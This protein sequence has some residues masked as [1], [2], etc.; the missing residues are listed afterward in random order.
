MKKTIGCLL[1]VFC[2]FYASGQTNITGQKVGFL[3]GKWKMG[4]KPYYEVWH[5]SEKGNLI[6]E[7]YSISNG[8]K[9]S[10]KKLRIVKGKEGLV[11]EIRYLKSKKKKVEFL[12]NDGIDDQLAFEVKNDG[13]LAKISY[14][15]ESDKKVV[16]HVTEPDGK[17]FSYYMIKQYPRRY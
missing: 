4:G 15:L 14:E 2:F 7:T 16:V 17:G 10:S 1:L 9:V 3:L 8:K 5:Q 13:A 12:H 6:G 11:Y